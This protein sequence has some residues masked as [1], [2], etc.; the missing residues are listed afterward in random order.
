M[1]RQN[2]FSHRGKTAVCERERDSIPNTSREPLMRVRALHTRVA[3]PH[4]SNLDLLHSAIFNYF[5]ENSII[6]FDTNSEVA[7]PR[8]ALRRCGEPPRRAFHARATRRIV[9]EFTTSG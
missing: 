2:A 7:T 8:I 3:A 1:H 4:G 6:F 5:L 9:C